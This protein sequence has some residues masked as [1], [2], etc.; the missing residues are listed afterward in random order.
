ML[1]P[2]KHR[3]PKK[4]TKPYASFPLTPHNNGQWCKKIRGTVH[5]FGVWEDPDAALQNYLRVAEA[6]HAGR[7]PRAESVPTN[8]LT[9]KDVCNHFLTYQLRRAETGEIGFRWAEDCRVVLECFARLVGAGRVVSDLGPDD[10][11]DFRQ[12]LL[13]KGLSGRKGLGV[14]ALSR[15]ITVVRGM[16]K[17][18]YE[19]DLI[20]R[21][22]KYGKAFE[23]PSAS[24]RRKSR[25]AAQVENGKR[26][27]A[28]QVIRTILR[29]AEPPLR[30][31][32]LLGINGGF[33]N[34][35]CA[36]L[37]TSAVDLDQGLVRFARPKTG[38]ERVVPLWPETV[39]A[40][41]AAVDQKPDVADEAAATLFFLTEDGTPWARDLVHRG[42]NG[43][44][45]KVIKGDYV[46]RHFGRLVRSL[47]LSRK[48]VGFYALRHTFRT[49]ADEVR[50][51]HA[52]HRIM[53]HAIPG[54]AGIY[55]EEISLDRLR[56]V[57]NHVRSK[58]FGT[59]E[60]PQPAAPT[61]A[62][63]T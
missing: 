39:E 10:F 3:R 55:V 44:V 43:E 54:M 21:P 19:T 35:D 20:D 8:A 25:M 57:V 24:L 60:I 48:G 56:A 22:M 40:M 52:I 7:K 12:R 46:G 30:A 50:D 53:G 17:Y 9:V 27:F 1:T 13:R 62:S 32:I 34:V 41:K 16:F 18:A 29:T 63:A 15:A 6:L 23:R 45:E 51:Q 31:M 4:P 5:F 28:P 61:S 2:R 37:V 58:L 36:R 42:Q 11:L 47:G 33:G 59:S 26:L 49:W 38:V 14:H